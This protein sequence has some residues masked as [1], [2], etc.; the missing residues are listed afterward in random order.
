MP[1]QVLANY[2]YSICMKSR[3]LRYYCDL[4]RVSHPVR[5]MSVKEGGE[6]KKEEK[7]MKERRKKK[8]NDGGDDD[9]DDS[10]CLHTGL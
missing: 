2:G 4:K 5:Y 9:Y 7:E 6:E 8:K 3:H 10:H 1:L